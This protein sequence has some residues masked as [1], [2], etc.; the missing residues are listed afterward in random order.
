MSL[1]DPKSLDFAWLGSGVF[2]RLSSKSSVDLD[3]LD[4]AWLGSGIFFGLSSSSVETETV[5]IDGNIAVISEQII[6]IDGYIKSEQIKEFTLDGNLGIQEKNF[7][8]DG[9]I[10]GTLAQEITLD[11]V[12]IERTIQS[13]TLDGEIAENVLVNVP[14]IGL[15][16]I[17]L[18]VPDLSSSVEINIDVVL[19]NLEIEWLLPYLVIKNIVLVAGG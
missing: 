3:S 7:T 16:E 14:V 11:G 19:G 1:P 17:Q 10:K 12:V 18:I 13:F 2:V 5:T 15:C 6:S 8:L 4:Y 9:Y